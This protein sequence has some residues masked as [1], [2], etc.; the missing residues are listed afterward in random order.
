[1]R[2]A[3]YIIGVGL[4]L[5]L[6]ASLAGQEP[7][8][9]PHCT[10]EVEGNR[11]ITLAGFPDGKTLG[12]PWRISTNGIQPAG[13]RQWSRTLRVEAEEL[14]TLDPETDERDRMDLV[15]RVEF[16]LEYEVQGNGEVLDRLAVLWCRAI[17]EV[18]KRNGPRE[19]I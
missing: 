1:M 9:E 19:T 7:I 6:P 11:L 15:R 17:Q 14:F 13:A 4:A 8:H 18:R 16:D 2:S 12:A 10:W 5:A 3:P